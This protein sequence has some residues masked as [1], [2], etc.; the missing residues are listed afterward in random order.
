MNSI[1]EISF[2]DIRGDFKMGK[3]FHQKQGY[4]RLQGVSTIKAAGVRALLLALIWLPEAQTAQITLPCRNEST[5]ETKNA[6]AEEQLTSCRSVIDETLTGSARYPGV[7]SNL[8]THMEDLYQGKAR[9]PNGPNAND[10]QTFDSIKKLCSFRRGPIQD[11]LISGRSDQSQGKSYGSDR[12]R[13]D[14]KNWRSEDCGLQTELLLDESGDLRCADPDDSP[15]FCR[16]PT[17]FSLK[18]TPSLPQGAGNASWEASHLASFYLMALEEAYLEIEAELRQSAGSSDGPK[19]TLDPALTAG[20]TQTNSQLEDLRLK[21]AGS[22]EPSPAPSSIVGR[23]NELG[24]TESK[25]LKSDNQDIFLKQMAS[26]FKTEVDRAAGTAKV[27][28]GL[29]SPSPGISSP[30][31]IELDSLRQRS[32]FL[33]MAWKSNQM[34]VQQLILAEIYLR[35]GKKLREADTVAINETHVQPFIRSTKDTCTSEVRSFGTIADCKVSKSCYVRKGNS[36]LKPKVAGF[37]A[38]LPRK[39]GVFPKLMNYTST[40]GN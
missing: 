21:V 31:K 19:V 29:A 23:T 14:S 22:T 25:T 40:T 18:L 7:I 1:G 10:V 17:S 38:S 37:M 15:P 2:L 13:E 28:L 27:T 3:L 5:Q 30:P 12:I 34:A 26:C 39:L 36:C 24:S 6:R 33:C 20:A 32:E 11:K 8:V 35:A 16:P 9:M 4:A